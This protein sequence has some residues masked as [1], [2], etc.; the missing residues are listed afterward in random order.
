MRD[1]LAERANRPSLAPTGQKLL[2][3][4]RQRVDAHADGVEF[5][6][7]H[8]VVY[9]IGEEVYFVMHG[10][11]LVR[12]AV[13]AQGLDCESEVHYLDGVPVARRQVDDHATPDEV[14]STA[15]GGGELLD[16]T[17]DLARARGGSRKAIHV[18]LHV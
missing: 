17:A 11:V 12:K 15:V 8:L 7:G 5:D 16:V 6:C 13:C 18:Y 2:L 9:L 10:R 4:V 1:L 14:Q 3:L